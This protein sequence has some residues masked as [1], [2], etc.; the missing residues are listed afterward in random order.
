MTSPFLKHCPLASCCHSL[1][2]TDHFFLTH[3]KYW[4]VSKVPSWTMFCHHS[5]HCT[6]V[7]PEMSCAF[8]GCSAHCPPVTLPRH[9]PRCLL[10]TFRSPQSLPSPMCH[11]LR[12][13]SHPSAPTTTTL[14]GLVTP[15]VLD[16]IVSASKTKEA[17]GQSRT[18]RLVGTADSPVPP[19]SPLPQ[20]VCLGVSRAG[21]PAA[22][23]C[24]CETIPPLPFFS[25]E[26]YSVVF[27]RRLTHAVSLPVWVSAV[28][29]VPLDNPSDF[30]LFIP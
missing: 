6:H 10:D 21:L 9:L 17:Q 5:T 15:A 4:P 20:P 22:P 19:R 1:L 8:H 3:P 26:T 13:H 29:S 7:I 18:C 16:T 28:S 27:W 30:S 11:P 14:Q 12:S 2:P 25:L 24:H 23:R